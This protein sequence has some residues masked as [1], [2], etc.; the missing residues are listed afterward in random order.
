MGSTGKTLDL[1]SPHPRKQLLELKSND[2]GLRML[3]LTVS[4]FS[5]CS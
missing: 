3:S 4:G 2:G 1:S 5:V